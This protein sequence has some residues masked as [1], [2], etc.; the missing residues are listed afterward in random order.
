MLKNGMGE[1]LRCI[2]CGA[3]LNHCPIYN[4]IGGHA[5]GWVYAGPIGAVLTPAFLGI[6]PAR[7][8]PHAT[9]FCGK[10]DEVCPVK[11]PLTRLHADWRERAFKSAPR[12]REQ[13]LR[14]YGRSSPGARASI[15]RPPVSRLPPSAPCSPRASRSAGCRSRAAGRARRDLPAPQGRTFQQL[16]AERAPEPPTQSAAMTR[17]AVFANIRSAL[18]ETGAQDRARAVAA[19]RAA[20][21]SPSLAR[22]RAARG[23]GS[24]RTLRGVPRSPGWCGCLD[25][26]RPRRSAGRG[27]RSRGV[28]RSGP[29]ARDRIR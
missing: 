6:G 22:L 3:C 2:R 21:A 20:S 10:C 1:A 29:V 9:T 16:W 12:K 5:Y 8:L 27:S 15:I 26:T 4:A 19:R 18:G 14:R 24:R 7:D 25:G 28:T 17:N 11:I 23:S 13:A